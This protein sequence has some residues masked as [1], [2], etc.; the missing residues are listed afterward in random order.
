MCRHAGCG[1]RELVELAYDMPVVFLQLSHDADLVAA[2]GE[3]G[4]PSWMRPGES[5]AGARDRLR[6]GREE[7]KRRAVAA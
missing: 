6:A 2:M 7:A 5:A 4:R 1:V 3:E